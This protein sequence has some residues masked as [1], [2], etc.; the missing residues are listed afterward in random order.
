MVR[1][2]SDLHVVC[3]SSVGPKY[4][5]SHD[6]GTTWDTP[7]TFAG[8]STFVAYSYCSV[9]IIYVDA[10]KK[11]NYLRNPTGNAGHCGVV[12][13][14]NADEIVNR[15]KVFPNPASYTLTIDLP[16]QSTIKILNMHGQLLE[17]RTTTDKSANIDVSSLPGGVYVVEVRTEKGIEVRKFVKE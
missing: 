1:N 11:I 2:G 5:H 14:I 9:H 15:I 4:F 8:S 6:G 16:A 7:F 12:T 3:G 17:S 13:G 10:N